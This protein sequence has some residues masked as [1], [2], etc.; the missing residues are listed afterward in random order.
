MWT[1]KKAWWQSDSM[2]EK[3]FNRILGIK[4][5]LFCLLLFFLYYCSISWSFVKMEICGIRDGRTEA[6]GTIPWQI[7]PS[8]FDMIVYVPWLYVQISHLYW[9]YSLAIYASVWNKIH[10]WWPYYTI[11]ALYTWK[12]SKQDLKQ[13][14]YTA[15]LRIYGRLIYF[16]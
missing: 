3:T 15:E 10:Q 13:K 9:G 16:S 11:H 14:I 5:A 6:K 12:K 4:L 1:E 8:N 7:L 2:D